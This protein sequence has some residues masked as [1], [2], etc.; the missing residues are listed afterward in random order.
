MTIPELIDQS[1]ETKSKFDPERKFLRVLP[2]VR[3]GTRVPTLARGV[4]RPSSPQIQARFVHLGR[5]EFATHGDW[6]GLDDM[7]HLWAPEAGDDWTTRI[8]LSRIAAEENWGNDAAALFRA[9]RLTLFACHPDGN[10]RIYLLWLDW[11]EEPELWA[12]DS[13]GE[14]R[15][16]DL[17]EYLSACVKLETYRYSRPWRL[18]RP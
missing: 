3:V 13:N 2:P 7:E 1:V 16:V 6:L 11:T 18:H 15:F 4:Y 8:N 14:L 5:W 9:D 10:E 12:Y 17:A